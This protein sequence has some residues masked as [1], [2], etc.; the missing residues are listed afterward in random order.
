MKNNFNLDNVDIE[1][2]SILSHDAKTS[3]AEI[4]KRLFVSGGT[5]HVR[6]KK[7]TE[8]GII[9]G[10][11]ITVDYQRLGY[12]VIAF[13]GIYLEQSQ[14][15]DQVCEELSKIPEIISSHYTTGEY[16]I[17]AKVICTDTDHLRNVLAKKIQKIAG[18]ARTVTFISLEEGINRPPTISDVPQTPK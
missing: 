18:I 2:L 4:G 15:Y 11:R 3:Y 6:I 14:L 7:L 5:I 17:F 13:L 10:S 9:V 1:I 8:L 12:D 16:S